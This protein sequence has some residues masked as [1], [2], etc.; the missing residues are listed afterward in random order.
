MNQGGFTGEL[1]KKIREKYSDWSDVQVFYD[2][3]NTKDE[4]TCSPTV[5]WGELNSRTRLGQLDIVVLVDGKV[6]IVCEIEETVSPPKKIIGDVYG[7]VLADSIRIKGK[8]YPIGDV[9]FLFAVK[10][11]D[12]PVKKAQLEELNEHVQK[13]LPSTSSNRMRVTFIGSPEFD[14]L[15]RQL[16]KTVDEIL[17]AV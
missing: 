4:F 12:S 1:G 8:E 7:V 2:H 5:F 10:L 15:E 13:N 9:D 14:E 17:R 3:L 6:R 11:D 16:L